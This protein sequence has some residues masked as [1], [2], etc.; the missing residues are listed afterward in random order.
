MD[1]P[2]AALRCVHGHFTTVHVAFTKGKLTPT[3]LSAA[4]L[5]K[6]K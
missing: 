6:L 1:G 2:T 3:P 4:H 5:K